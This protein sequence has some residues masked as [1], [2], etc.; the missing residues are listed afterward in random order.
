MKIYARRLFILFWGISA[1]ILSH[2]RLYAQIGTW[3]EVATTAPHANEGVMLLLTDGT[4]ICHTTQG[5]SYGTG[6]DKLTPDSTGSYVNGTWST[7]AQMSYNRLFFSSQVLPSG[8][9]I[10]EISSDLLD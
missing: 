3:T 2:N 10:Q 8:K 1:S 5:G 9:V 6:W 7:I 4:V